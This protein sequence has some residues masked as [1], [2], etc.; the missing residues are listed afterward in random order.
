MQDMNWMDAIFTDAQLK[1]AVDLLGQRNVF[2][3]PPA[4]FPDMTNPMYD[5]VPQR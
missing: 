3:R 5:I 4:V 1:A 2:S